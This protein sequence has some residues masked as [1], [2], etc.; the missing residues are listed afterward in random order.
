MQSPDGGELVL[1]WLKRKPDLVASRAGH[2]VVGAHVELHHRARRAV[3]DRGAERPAGAR[4]VRRNVTR[5]CSAT[6][7]RIR[8]DARKETARRPRRSPASTPN[9]PS[10]PPAAGSTTTTTSC[11]PPNGHAGRHRA[12]TERRMS[13]VPARPQHQWSFRPRLGHNGPRTGGHRRPRCRQATDSRCPKPP[14]TTSSRCGSRVGP[15]ART[16]QPRRGG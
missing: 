6:C 14:F 1:N 7:G 2:E 8:A 10:W 11:G 5:N 3:D 13:D 16:S 9:R 4:V 15:A 12:S